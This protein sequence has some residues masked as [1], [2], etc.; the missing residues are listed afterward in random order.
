MTIAATPSLRGKSVLNGL[1]TRILGLVL[2]PALILGAG[3]IWQSNKTTGTMIKSLNHVSGQS[4]LVMETQANIQ[5]ALVASNK[6]VAITSEVATEQQLGL[7]RNDVSALG[8]GQ[9]RIKHMNEVVKSYKEAIAALEP[10][11]EIIKKTAE[12]ELIRKFEY[13]M[14]NT[15]IVEKLLVLAVESHERTNLLLAQNALDSARANY[16]FE[17]RFKMEAAITRL[18]RAS[19]M[20]VDASFAVERITKENF[21]A[22][23]QS[24]IDSTIA[25]NRVTI[26]GVSILLVAIII[27]AILTSYLSI[28]R[29]MKSA[30]R[31]L[32]SLANGE[33]D[34]TLPKA[35]INEIRDLS[36]SM[37][38]FRTNMLENRDLEA[39]R[40]KERE[41]A[42]LHQRAVLHDL[43]D[44]FEQ[45]VGTIVGSVSSGANQQRGTAQ[46]MSQSVT[47]MSTQSGVVMN[48]ANDADSSLQTIAAA[49]EELA[50]SVQEIGRRA[51]ESAEKAIHVSTATK[52]TV[53]EVSKLA[54]TAEAIGS[55]VNLIQDIAGQTNLLALNATIEAARAG[56]A[57]RGFAVVAS[58]VKSLASQTEKATAEIS[59]QILAIQSGTEA[60]MNAIALTSTI[61]EEL[62]T[63]SHGI[64]S[65]VKEQSKATDEIAESVNYFAESNKNVTRNIASISDATG[66]VAN[67]ANEMLTAA[68]ELSQTADMLSS[69]VAEFLSTVR[70][71]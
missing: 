40:L 35:S 38:F 56:D 20:L 22:M 33:L 42:A 59:Q 68:D 67:S 44:R 57:G 6:L 64:A 48:I 12:A 27:A 24:V 31:A 25:A 2:L 13:V 53:G 18:T 71:G 10:V 49:A 19:Q 62:S 66:G 58:E 30:V 26:L 70:A 17:E 65:A 69:E 54:Q 37:E 32:T 1:T 45:S 23:A 51:N 61:I 15:G 55:I 50:S 47:D 9:A 39:A 52:N 63:I 7:L 60:S 8:A 41:E 21:N 14:R 46:S 43:A 5:A 11:Q 3:L 34:V 28:A 29:P 36:H 4:N 16:L